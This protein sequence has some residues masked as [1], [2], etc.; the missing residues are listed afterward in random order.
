MTTHPVVIVGAGPTGATLALLLAAHGVRTVV[1][2]RRDS[3]QTHPAAHV[4]STRTLEVF[5][6][7]GLEREV[8]RLSSRPHETRDVVYATTLAGPELGRI[9][10]AN[11]DSPDAERI[12]ALSPTRSAN[13][14]QHTLEPLL[15]ERLKANALIDFRPSSRYAFHVQAPD[16]VTVG[17][18][19]AGTTDQIVGS[20]LVAADGAGSRVRRNAGISMSG[21][22]LQHLIS[23]HCRVDL[24]R[25]L[26]S[27]R[28]PVIWTHS[29]R[30]VGT[31]IVHRA[32]DDLVFQIPYFPP[33]QQ[34]TDFT[35]RRCER[36]IRSAIGDREVPVEIR[37][38]QGWTMTAQV[39]ERYREGRVVLAGDAAHRFPPTG[40]L[41]LNT[42]VG[43]AHNLAWKLAWTL[44]GTDSDA[45][46]DSY[47]RERRPI[48]IRNSAHSAHN[49]DGLLD[50]LD[51]L[52]LSRTGQ[53]ALRRITGSRPFRALPRP[54]ASALATALMTAGMARLTGLSADT[55]R[56]RRR[57]AGIGAVI[58]QQSG[59]YRMWGL[60]L[61]VCYHDGILSG[62][63]N[64]PDTASAEDYTP[65]IRVGGRLPHAWVDHD[66]VR[67]ST[68]DMPARDRFTVFAQPA[69]ASRWATEAV[70]VAAVDFRCAGGPFA[71]LSTGTALVVRP[72]GHIAA[73]IAAAGH[74][75][76]AL[77]DTLIQLN[78]P[79]KG[80]AD[81]R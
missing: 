62:P 64:A 81:V 28:A 39:A 59:H 79:T 58:A 76:A 71:E 12:E 57:R 73:V 16:W 63:D 80:H 13:L 10:I 36:L 15:W 20:Y 31:F 61:G 49:F 35:P 67:V 11:P 7:L 42:G 1:L 74:E 53:Q 18:D 41:G 40:G 72:D 70:G 4:L 75:Q 23:V 24:R 50:V 34:V 78:Q 6:E 60:D 19:R 56:G 46:L 30:G 21:P 33:A 48:A 3:P 47:E 68:L 14:P 38:V 32:P 37:S 52:G 51:E 77:R 45:L 25:Y 2:E 8:R 69:T 65:T 29:P 5:R 22:V 9:T 43:D 27:R 26:W 17:V 54:V 66:G 44:A 55:H